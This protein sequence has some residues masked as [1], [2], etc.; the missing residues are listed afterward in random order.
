MKLSEIVVHEYQCPCRKL[1]KLEDPSGD[2]DYAL[3][4]HPHPEACPF[5]VVGCET[6]EFRNFQMEVPPY[7]AIYP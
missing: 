3:K 7:P 2:S 5:K 4:V 1:A 6:L